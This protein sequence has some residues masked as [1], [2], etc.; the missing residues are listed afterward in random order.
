MDEQKRLEEEEALDR[1]FEEAFTGRVGERVLKDL[2]Y[3]CA[4]DDVCFGKDDRETNF[5]LGARSIFCYIKKRLKDAEN[6]KT[7]KNRQ[8]TYKDE[9]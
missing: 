6:R 9:S 1:C 2:R 7:N 5:N 4:Y 8:E 3:R